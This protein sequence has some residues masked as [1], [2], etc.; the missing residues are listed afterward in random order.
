M[1]L[2]TAV[3]IGLTVSTARPAGIIA[4]L[5]LLPVLTF[6]QPS[7]R[8]CYATAVGYY[9]GALWPLALGARNFFGP[10]VSAVG[11]LGF[12]AICALLLSLPYALLWTNKTVSLTWRAP[13]A[14]LIGVIPPLGLIGFASPLTAAGFL[15]PGWSWVGFGLA[16]TGCGFIA[17][18]PK[19]GAA[20]VV[21]AALSANLLYPGDRQPPPGWQALNTSFGGISHERVSPL[22][23]YL[24]AQQIQTEAT[25]SSA[26]VI[27][28]PESVVRA[29]TDSTDLF[30]K[31]S[32]DDLRQNGKIVLIGALIPESLPRPAESYSYLN[33]AIMRGAQTGIFLQ[34][35][36]VPVSVW[37]PFSRSGAPLH[38]A[39]SPVLDIAGQRAAVLICYEQVIPWTA[40][41]AAIARPTIFVG[42]ANDYWATGTTIPQWQRLC[43]RSWSRLFGIP[44]LLAVNT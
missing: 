41:T 40:L 19:I 1:R 14:L 17:V 44:Y 31:R 7:R 13:V 15:F 22:H 9:A 10:D 39:G 35:V 20:G 18:Y 21:A 38:L 34:R 30:W 24:L 8:K 6:R 11:A 16:L 42:M 27:V 26:K 37:K 25:A 28:F 29:W 32:I 23:A 12:W 36:P 5:L 3:A 2:L 33:A 4:A 43:L